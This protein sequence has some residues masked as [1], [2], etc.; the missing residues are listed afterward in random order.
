MFEFSKLAG[1]AATH[2]ML[3]INHWRERFEEGAGDDGVM[4]V[5]QQ[6]MAHW[7]QR[8]AHQEDLEEALDKRRQLINYNNFNGGK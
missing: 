8:K 4:Q 6:R 3:M 1:E 7:E 2:S 5:C